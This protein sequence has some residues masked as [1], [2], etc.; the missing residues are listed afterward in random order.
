MPTAHFFSFSSDVLRLPEPKWM[1]MGVRFVNVNGV[2][3]PYPR[4]RD[5]EIGTER[6]LVTFPGSHSS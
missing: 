6:G 5:M 1:H 3:P 4:F 2:V